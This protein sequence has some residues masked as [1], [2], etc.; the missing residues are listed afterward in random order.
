MCIYVS[1][2]VSEKPVE[3][4]C[5]PRYSVYVFVFEWYIALTAEFQGLVLREH[6]QSDYLHQTLQRTMVMIRDMYVIHDLAL[7]LQRAGSL[8]GGK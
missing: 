7:K 6:P 4:C 2:Y 3:S 1:V 5:A 8:D